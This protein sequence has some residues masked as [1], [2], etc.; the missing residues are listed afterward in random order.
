MALF[1]EKLGYTYSIKKASSRIPIC[2]LNVSCGQDFVS[3][4]V[5]SVKLKL[6]F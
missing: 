2:Q 1:S 5:Y 3:G 4:I 6:L